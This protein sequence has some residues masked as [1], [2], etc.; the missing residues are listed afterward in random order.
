MIRDILEIGSVVSGIIIMLVICVPIYR[1]MRRQ[2][3]ADAEQ[4]KQFDII[5]NKKKGKK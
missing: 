4:R 2:K 5:Y 3:R 1:E